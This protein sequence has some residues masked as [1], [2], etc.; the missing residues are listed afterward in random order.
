MSAVWSFC[1]RCLDVISPGNQSDGVAKCRLFCALRPW[2]I[3][4]SGSIL[5]LARV[6]KSDK[7][8]YRIL[9]EIYIYIYI[10]LADF[11]NTNLTKSAVIWVKSCQNAGFLRPISSKI[12]P[13]KEKERRKSKSKERERR[14]REKT[15]VALL[16]FIM[17]TF[18]GRKKK[19]LDG[20][21]L[22]GDNVF[23]NPARYILRS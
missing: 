1:A 3:S 13:T 19:L 8:K 23:K 11:F 14:R 2:D 17:D 21:G 6:A 7:K 9:F 5:Q 22:F 20:R 10:Y 16:V 12:T 4:L 18:F 15:M